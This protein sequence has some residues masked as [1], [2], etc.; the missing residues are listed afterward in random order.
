M[1]LSCC[2]CFRNEYYNDNV[3]LPVFQCGR[4][5]YTVAE[6]VSILLGNVSKEKVCKAQPVNVEHN[7]S[8]V[9]DLSCVN[10]PND[11]RADDSGVW[12]H[13]GVRKSWVVMDNTRN[14]LF[15]SRERPP[16]KQDIPQNGR[17]Y[18]LT[19]VYHAL[20]ESND[21]RR[22]IVTLQGGFGKCYLIS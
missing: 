22:M 14:I 2:F 13:Q 19:R 9:V 10:D 7:C 6:L 8:F 16:Q 20:Q 5:E 18:V 21:F 3:D 15:Q 12:K 4:M 1:L 17:Q 11:L